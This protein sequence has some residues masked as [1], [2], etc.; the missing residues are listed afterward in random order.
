MGAVMP[1]GGSG[2][3]TTPQPGRRGESTGEGEHREEPS[4]YLL[5]RWR[6]LARPQRFLVEE[7]IREQERNLAAT[8]EEKPW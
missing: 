3:V 5:L 6:H 7:L 8:G 2:P 1:D 4:P